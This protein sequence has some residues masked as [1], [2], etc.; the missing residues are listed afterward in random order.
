MAAEDIGE[1]IPT[2]VPGYSDAADIQAALRLYHYGSYSFDINETDDTQLINPSI[3]Y[4]INDLQNQLDAITTG[5]LG[6]DFNAKGDLLSASAND[7]PLIL[8]VG[9]TG[10]VLTVNPSTATGLE[11]QTPAITTTNTVTLT[12]KTLTAPVLTTSFNSQTGTTYTLALTD[13]SKM[14][15]LSN[16]SAITVTIPTNAS[17]A[18]PIGTQ[19][20]LVQKGAGQPTIVGDT[21]VTL[22]GI[23]TKLRLQWSSGSLLKTD[24]N[25]WLLVGDIVP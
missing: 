21:G 15:T 10:Q 24:T 11:W 5:I 16:A 6:S 20:D 13:A 23:G 2:K 14:I 1:L 19:I 18:F 4:T 17:V 3:A 9:T 22:N 8:S 25:E 7:T 12:N